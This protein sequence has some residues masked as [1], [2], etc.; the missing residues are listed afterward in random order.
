MAETGPICGNFDG[1]GPTSSPRKTVN[2]SEK[3]LRAMST[4]EKPYSKG[5]IQFFDGQGGDVGSITRND[6]HTIIRFGQTRC[7]AKA[8]SQEFN[9]CVTQVEGGV[10]IV[11]D[12]SGT[13]VRE[14]EFQTARAKSAPEGVALPKLKGLLPEI[15]VTPLR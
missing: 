15:F 2:E 5:Y 8:G 11:Q 3:E 12:N 10:E 14:S 13:Y 1:I 9:K 4:A 6:K 7:E